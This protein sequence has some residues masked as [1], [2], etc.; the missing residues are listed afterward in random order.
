MMKKLITNQTLPFIMGRVKLVVSKP[1][2]VVPSVFCDS[3][4]RAKVMKT[5]VILKFIQ[6][7]SV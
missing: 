5:K 4:P 1:L 6:K 7:L 2:P 3:D